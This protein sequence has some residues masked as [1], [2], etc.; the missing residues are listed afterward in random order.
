MRSIRLAVAGADTLRPSNPLFPQPYSTVAGENRL[1]VGRAASGPFVPE[2]EMKPVILA[3][4]LSLQ[5]ASITPG[6][7][8]AGE[9]WYMGA[10]ASSCGALVEAA[11]KSSAADLEASFGFQQ[12][13]DGYLSAVNDARGSLG[14][15]SMLG[16]ETDADGRDV[17][18]LNYCRAHPLEPVF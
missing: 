7:A 12:W 13:I 17:W 1:D 9:S 6:E 3:V 15:S 5:V 18:I 8:Q 2:G 14:K 10:G 11:P 4:I 16:H